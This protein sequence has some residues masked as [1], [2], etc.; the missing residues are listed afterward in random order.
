M[1]SLTQKNQSMKL[2]LMKLWGEFVGVKIII[3]VVQKVFGY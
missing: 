2:T 1:H 3:T